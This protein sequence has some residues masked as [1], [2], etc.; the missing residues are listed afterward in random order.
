MKKEKKPQEPETTKID[1]RAKIS[2]QKRKRFFLSK[3]VTLQKMKLFD[4]GSE[5]V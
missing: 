4:N 1:I 5:Q 3:R 2:G